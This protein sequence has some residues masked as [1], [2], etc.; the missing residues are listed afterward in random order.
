MVMDCMASLCVRSIVT[1]G[2]SLRSVSSTCFCY[3]FNS[4]PAYMPNTSFLIQKGGSFG[5]HCVQSASSTMISC[6]T[7]D[8]SPLGHLCRVHPCSTLQQYSVLHCAPITQDQKLP[9]IFTIPPTS[10]ASRMQL[11]TFGELLCK[12]K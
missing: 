1:S 2:M 8:S 3:I 11:L 12:K 7:N 4:C 5:A 9:C 10:C 6:N